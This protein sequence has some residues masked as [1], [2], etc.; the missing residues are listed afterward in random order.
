MTISVNNHKVSNHQLAPQQS[1]S[2]A[3]IIGQ[4]L[5]SAFADAIESDLESLR[6]IN[7]L[8]EQLSK[9]NQQN[10][11]LNDF[12]SIETLSILLLSL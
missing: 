8:T 1:P 4:M 9:K 12:N 2:I 7:R 11:V 5:N 3:T 10:D 6:K